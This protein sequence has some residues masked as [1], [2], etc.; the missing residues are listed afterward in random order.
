ML[1]DFFTKPLQGALFTK[2]RDVILGYKHIDSLATSSPTPSVEERVGE[3]SRSD[4]TGNFEPAKENN[5]DNDGWVTVTRKTRRQ[6]SK[7]VST[8]C[9]VRLVRES[10]SRNNPGSKDEV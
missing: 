9:S 10:F 3:E 8:P 5:T 4:G 1:G 2:F 7:A 6:N